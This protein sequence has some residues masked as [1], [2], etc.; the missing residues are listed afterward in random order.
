ML[1]RSTAL[2]GGGFAYL[3]DKK[4]TALN[5]ARTGS[6][7][8]FQLDQQF[9]SFGFGSGLSH[10]FAPVYRLALAVAVHTPKADVY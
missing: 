6:I 2:W 9:G 5:T 4:A 1:F 10:D 3:I 8:A 7:S